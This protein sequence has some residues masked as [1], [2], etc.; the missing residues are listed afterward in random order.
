MSGE[1]SLGYSCGV[2]PKVQINAGRLYML[3]HQ[4]SLT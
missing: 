2:T 4:T 1:G 3:N